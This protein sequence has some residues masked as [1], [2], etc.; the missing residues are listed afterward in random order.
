[1][2]GEIRRLAAFPFMTSETVDSE[3][4]AAAATFNS[5][6]GL[7]MLKLYIKA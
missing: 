4:P 2:V 5:V 6:M 1:V 7:L 3:T